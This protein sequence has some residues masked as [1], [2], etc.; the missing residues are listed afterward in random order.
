MSIMKGVVMD[1][2]RP[3]ECYRKYYVMEQFEPK[4]CQCFFKCKYNPPKKLAPIEVTYNKNLHD[5]ASFL[6]NKKMKN[7][8]D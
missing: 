1:V 5:S 7:N 8:I 4:K 3:T 6:V 2:F